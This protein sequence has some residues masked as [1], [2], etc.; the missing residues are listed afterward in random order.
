MWG[1]VGDSYELLRTIGQSRAIGQEQSQLQALALLCRMR[2]ETM[3][4]MGWLQG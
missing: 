1:L 2:L 3:P 4:G